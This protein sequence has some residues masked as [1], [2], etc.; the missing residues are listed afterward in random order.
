MGDEEYR[1]QGQGHGVGPDDSEKDI[2]FEQYTYPGQ[3]FDDMGSVAMLLGNAGAAG[4][5]MTST[6]LR[7]TDVNDLASLFLGGTPPAYE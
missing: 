4:I 1:A 7:R 2:Y 3:W 6:P 5:D